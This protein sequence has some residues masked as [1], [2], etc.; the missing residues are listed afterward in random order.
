MAGGK[1]A[2]EKERAAV[3]EQ[4]EIVAICG[5]DGAVIGALPRARVREENLAHRCSAIGE[6]V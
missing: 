3:E 1:T 4:G 2:F 5:E 6:C